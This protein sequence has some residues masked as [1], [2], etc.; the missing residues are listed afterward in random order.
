MSLLKQWPVFFL[1]LAFAMSPFFAGQEKMVLALIHILVLVVIIKGL[2]S[3]SSNQEFRIPFNSLVLSICLF[4]IWMGLSINWSPA[5]SIS[6]YM[7]VWLS[8]FPLCFF[9][10]SLKQVDGWSYLKFGLLFVTLI[11]AFIGITQVITLGELPPMYLMLFTRN[12][13]A[14]LLNLIALPTTSWFFVLLG[15]SQTR[16]SII[17]GLA[18]FVFFLAIF[19]TGSR[20]GFI[21]LL[22]GLV[23]IVVTCREYV[24]KSSITKL[25]IIITISFI[26]ANILTSNLPVHRLEESKTFVSNP[27]ADMRLLIWKSAWQIV[28]SAAVIGTGI[29]TYY[30]VSPPFRHPDDD[31]SGIFVHNDYLQFWLET[32]F[33]GLCM[34]LFIMISISR[35]FIVLLDHKKLKPQDKYEATGLMAGLFTISIHSF[36]DFNFYIVAIL[37]LMGL[38]CAR[39]QEILGEYY[40]DFIYY[41]IPSNKMF[42]KVLML[43][44]GIISVLLMSYNLSAAIAEF[45][46]Y[47]AKRQFA[48]GQ[49]HNSESNLDLGAK[50]D[51]NSLRICFQQVQLYRSVLNMIKNEASEVERKKLM[52]KALMVLKIIEDINKLDGFAPENRGHLLVEN[53]DIAIYNW[54]EKAMNEYKNALRVRPEQYRA[55]IALAKLL[56]QQGKLD[57]AV[58]LI[59]NGVNYFYLFKHSELDEF[60]QYAIK[61]NLMNGDTVKA[62]E[63]QIEKGLLLDKQ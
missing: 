37:M 38:M 21:S 29:G 52:G 1:L 13:Y 35:F 15:R 48:N 58:D 27:S 2:V 26:C 25:I 22:L 5:P 59:N 18:L 3:P 31:S 62:K 32:G 9:S 40:P 24:N 42:H 4:Y 14:G 39:I 34:L 36:V 54:Y 57:E 44:M 7:F 45:Y 61:L 55:R 50:W 11:F 30:I 53:S 23:F 17:L 41:S 51:P 10:Y 12:T 33:I 46:W 8:I 20:G 63:I 47:K 56:E 60:Y 16:W 6:L 19:Q 28:E 43:G 49:I